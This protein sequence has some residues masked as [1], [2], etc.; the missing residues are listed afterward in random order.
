MSN[1][2]QSFPPSNEPNPGGYGN[3]SSNYGNYDHA[4]YSQN[5]YSQPANQYAPFPGQQNQLIAGPRPGAW[6]RFL[7]FLIDYII[8]SIV[9][10][11]I[12]YVLFKEDLDTF[13]KAS[14]SS[15]PGTNPPE[16]PIAALL[17]AALL[18]FVLWF[19]YRMIMEVKYEGT[20][21][22]KAIGARV[23]MEE[24][25]PISYGSSFKRNSWFL[26]TLLT[27][28][29]PSGSLIIQVILGVSIAKDANKQSFSDKWAK[30]VVIDKT[31]R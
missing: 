3:Q 4:T 25:G 13:F 17:V 18:T 8:L 1:S 21:G 27:S 11:L 20:L 9:T 24:G 15:T 5:A 10:C 30:A 12:T 23:A 6:K 16:E 7:G 26:L 14:F 22:K 28:F 19:A 29:L 31:V 2:Y